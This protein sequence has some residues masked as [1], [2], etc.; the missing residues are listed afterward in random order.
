MKKTILTLIGA[1]ILSTN[2][3]GASSSIILNGN[4]ISLENPVKIEEGRSYVPLREIGENILEAKVVWDAAN[5]AAVLS[6]NGITIIVPIGSNNITVNGS[7]RYIEYPA[8]V[9]DGKTYVPV[10]A[11][12]EGFNY[13]VGYSNSTITIKDRDNQPTVEEADNIS[14]D[15][16]QFSNLESNETLAVMHTNFGNITFRFF[17]KYAPKAVENFITHAKEGYY[18]GITFHRVIND[19]VIQGGDPEGT[20]TGGESI[21]GDYF[22]DEVTPELRHFRGALAM[23]NAG[24]NTNGS[25]FFIVQSKDASEQIK[26]IKNAENTP[27]ISQLFPDDII[28]A[29]EKYGG[30]PSLDFSYTVFGQVIDGMDVVDLIASIPTDISDKPLRDVIIDKIEIK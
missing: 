28:N 9:E 8:F 22:E 2:V 15:L 21:W 20:G 25:Q 16:L 27:E 13:S 26:A 19:F 23:A 7:N 10:R 5:K 24:P 12:A 11:I 6:K 17:P 18:D 30:Y 4:R 1:A 29:Y 3:L 14:S